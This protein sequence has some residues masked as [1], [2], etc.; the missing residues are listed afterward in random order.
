[1]TTLDKWTELAEQ[2]GD[3]LGEKQAFAIPTARALLSGLGR[4]AAAP[5]KAMWNKPGITATGLGAGSVGA[6]GINNQLEANINQ[7]Q[8]QLDYAQSVDNLHVPRPAQQLD[9]G[10]MQP[11]DVLKWSLALGL[12]LGALAMMGNR[13]RPREQGE[14]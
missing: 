9:S 5:A 2:T 3:L 4:G 14:L 7:M 10:G 8:D 11:Y 6:S 12:P 13:R 1:M